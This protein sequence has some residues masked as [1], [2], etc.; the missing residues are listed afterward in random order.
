MQTGQTNKQT[1]KHKSS[2]N[3]IDIRTTAAK[4]HPFPIETRAEV[5]ELS[6]A[7]KSER[8]IAI[9]HFFKKAS[10]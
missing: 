8:Q 6:K 9:E 5:I 3:H 10:P 7:G 2:F 4:R 1:H